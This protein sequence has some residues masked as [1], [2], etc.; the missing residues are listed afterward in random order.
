MDKKKQKILEQAAKMGFVESKQKITR[1]RKPMSAEQK[2]AAAE[3]LAKA[4]LARGHDGSKSIHVSLRDKAESDPMHWKK[5][6]EWITYQESRLDVLV[7]KKEITE[8]NGYITAMKKYLKS[9]EWGWYSWGKDMENKMQRICI[10]MGYYKNGM[11]KR[12]TN[13]WYK[14]IQRVWTEAD[15]V[16]YQAELKLML[17][18]GERLY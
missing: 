15:N 6:K 3:R 8:C 13:V 2:E 12:Q 16:E 14:D 4:R 17:K 9:G 1:K 7:N 5:V 10:A 18:R 11:P